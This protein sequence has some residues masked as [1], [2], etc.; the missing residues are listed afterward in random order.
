M[1]PSAVDGRWVH[2]F[3]SIPICN[4]GL[5]GTLLN[6]EVTDA[7]ENEIKKK[8]SV[9]RVMRSRLCRPFRV[10]GGRWRPLIVFFYY[11][12]AVVVVENCLIAWYALAGGEGRLFPVISHN[13]NNNSA[14]G[15][16]SI[17]GSPPTAFV[18]YHYEIQP[19]LRSSAAHAGNASTTSTSASTSRPEVVAPLVRRA[20]A[21]AR[22]ASSSTT[23]DVAA[24]EKAFYRR[25]STRV[26]PFRHR[27]RLVPPA[28]CRNDT[29]LIILIHSH[30]RYSD[31]REAIRKTW[32]N[33][34]T[35]G[36]WPGNRA[37]S[38]GLSSEE[39]GDGVNRQGSCCS[40]MQ[41]AFVIGLNKDPGVNDA[42]EEEYLTHWDIIQVNK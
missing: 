3:H 25:R 7:S 33:A 24:L 1:L 21:S 11:V 29:R 10:R 4:A 35:T 23:V 26:N 8:L 37:P 20:V 34:V 38:G 36:R 40:S 22:V 16:I 28:I 12:L 5:S 9:D 31:R 18:F 6:A 27:A 32:G 39:T 41:L 14:S 15:P 19:I 2:G 42:V 30:P 13:N 17:S